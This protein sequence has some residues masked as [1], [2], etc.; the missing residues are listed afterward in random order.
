[1]S[2]PE[3]AE[4]EDEK[5]SIVNDTHATHAHREVDTIGT[6]NGNDDDDIDDVGALY[7]SYINRNFAVPSRTS[8]SLSKEKQ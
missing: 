1:M 2:S 4:Q 6:N 8:D 5:R 3:S 7:V